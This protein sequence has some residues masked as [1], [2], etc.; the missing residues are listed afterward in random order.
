MEPGL[1]RGKVASQVRKYAGLGLLRPVGIDED[2]GRKPFLYEMD[3]VLIAKTLSTLGWTTLDIVA[4]GDGPDSIAREVST[5]LKGF[6]LGD[7][8]PDGVPKGENV[9]ATLKRLG[10]WPAAR[11]L[12]DWNQ[13]VGGWSLHVRW[14]VDDATGKR[15][16]RCKLWNASNGFTPSFMS[17]PEPLPH[18]EI[19]VPF[20]RLL[21]VITSNRKAMN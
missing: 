8:F 19:I 18:A 5:A 12:L 9:Q 10:G 3:S 15:R 2:D 13:G 6:N 1:D 4:G 14:F 20:D 11:V 21:P 7:V 17:Y 16:V